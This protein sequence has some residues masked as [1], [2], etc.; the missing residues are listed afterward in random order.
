MQIGNWAGLASLDFMVVDRRCENLCKSEQKKYKKY[1]GCVML[2]GIN[3]LIK[4][5]TLV[6]A[7]RRSGVCKSKAVRSR[8]GSLIPR[9]AISRRLINDPLKRLSPYSLAPSLRILVKCCLI[10]IQINKLF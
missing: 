5:F 8:S 2:L 3:F 6:F 4:K 10:N 7:L 9:S 1:I